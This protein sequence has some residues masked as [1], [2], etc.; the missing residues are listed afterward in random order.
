MKPTILIAV[1]ITLGLLIL[2]IILIVDLHQA[3]DNEV[4]NRFH[5][6]QSMI[7][8]HLTREIEQYLR[9]RSRG[10]QVLC[11]F[12]SLQHRDMKKMPA[13]IQEYFQL[14][15]L[16]SFAVFM[17]M[18]FLFGYT[19]ERIKKANRKTADEVARGANP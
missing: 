12:A 3:S 18:G 2:S 14:L 16:A 13:D 17:G 9:D 4:I 10:A 5:D 19:Q 8:R 6:H 11:T 15:Y 1:I 7:V